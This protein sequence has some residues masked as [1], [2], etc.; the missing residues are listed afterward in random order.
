VLFILIGTLLLMANLN[1]EIRIW[2]WLADYW[3]VILILWGLAKLAD[4][5]MSRRTGELPPRTLGVGEVFLLLLIIGIGSAT[6]GIV[7]I[8]DR[9]PDLIEIFPPELGGE[10]FTY[11]EEAPAT[12][13]VK[14]GAVIRVTNYRGD[15]RV[16]A[17]EAGDLRVIVKKEVRAWNETEAARMSQG[18]S[19][20]VRPT[21]DGYEI[22]PE[23][24]DEKYKRIRMDMEIHVPRTVQVDLNTDRGGVG[25]T[26]INGNITASSYRGDVQIASAGGD[27]RVDAKGGDIRVTNVK[28]AVRISGRGSEIEVADVAGEAVIQG[29]FFGPIRARNVAKEV[30]FLSQR[31]DLTI[32][33]LPGRMEMGS[34]QLEIY[35]TPGSV[36]CLTRNKDIL[37]E[38][39]GGRVRI[40]NRRGNVSLRLRQPPREEIDIANESGSVELTLPAS[41]TFELTA[42]SRQG[43][44]ES[45][46]EGPGLNISRDSKTAT[47]QG[48]VGARGPKVQLKTTY[49]PVRIRKN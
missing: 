32:S 49:G 9:N 43:D 28:G 10:A 18:M 5:F 1:A 26:G 12:A 21:S 39:I 2:R 17:E 38:N 19:V 4:Y 16:H 35:D 11:T 24:K 48:Q 40:E 27:V 34:G 8:R 15:I 47:L 14:P 44:V 45:D 23:L 42:S 20:S 13:A 37:L 31:T 22:K 30:H 7:H 25:I 33:Q 29:E 46:F 3:P 41:S 6:A 36:S